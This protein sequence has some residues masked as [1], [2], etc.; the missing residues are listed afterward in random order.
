MKKTLFTSAA[1]G[2]IIA[3]GLATSAMADGHAT[4]L[5]LCWA[6]W[7]PANSLIELSKDFEK[8]SGHTMNFRVRPLDK[9]C[10]PY[11]ERI[12]LGRAAV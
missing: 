10:R 11:A 12:E 6:A 3:S 2:A 5:T 9:F 8:Q 1:A 7:D 4:D